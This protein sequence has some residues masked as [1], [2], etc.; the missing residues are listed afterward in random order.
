MT[1]L[2]S[3]ASSK[4][5]EDDGVPDYIRDHVEAVARIRAQMIEEESRVIARGG[6]M[7]LDNTASGPGRD[8]VGYGWMA[9]R[10]D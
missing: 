4:M 5:C 9:R 10:G 3:E 8:P 2:S 7:P 6:L 1:S